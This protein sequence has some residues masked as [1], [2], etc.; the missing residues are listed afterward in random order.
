M[1]NLLTSPYSKDLPYWKKQSPPIKDQKFTD[2]LFPPNINSLLSKNEN[3][4][5]LDFKHGPKMEKRIKTEEI[6][7]MRA[8]EIFKNEKYSLFEKQIKISEISQGSL[9]DCYFLASIASLT[10]YPKLIYQ[11]FKTKNINNE[12]YFELIIFIDGKFQIVIVDD[13][14]PINIKNKRICFSRPYNN[15]IWICILE[16]AWAKINGGYTNIIKGWM[17][18]VL[19]AF[20][21]FQSEIIKHN[22]IKY[23][24][25]WEKIAEAKNNNFIITCSTRN[26]VDKYGL[27]NNHAYSFFGCT[28]IISN[29]KKIKLVKIRNI[30]KNKN[31]HGDWGD[32]SPLWGEEEKKQV[33]YYGKIKGL[34]YMS[35]Q[36]FYNYFDLTEICYVLYNSYSKNI[37]IN[38]QN[39]NN[40][41]IFNLY[42]EEDGY[43]FISLIRKMWR[44]NRQLVNTIIPSYLLIVSY[45]PLN[46]KINNY[47]YDYDA[48]NESYED[49]SLI[50]YL[51]KG[52][53]LIYAYHDLFHS[54]LKKE[55]FYIIKFDSTVKFKYKLMPNDHREKDFILLKNI[56]K[57]ILLDKYKDCILDQKYIYIGN[58][59]DKD[60]IGYKMIYN[61]KNHWIK[62][63]EDCSELKNVFILSSNLKDKNHEEEYEYIIP[64]KGF[65]IILGLPIDT[66]S[67]SDFVLKSKAFILEKKPKNILKNNLE[68][69]IK[70]YANNSVYYEDNN[71]SNFYDYLFIS[72]NDSKED[73]IPT[74]NLEESNINENTDSK[75]PKIMK[76]LEKVKNSDNTERLT[77][78]IIN[79]QNCEYIGQVNNLKQKEGKGCL[80]YKNSDHVL[81]GNFKNGKINGNGTVYNKN[82]DKIY[83]EG[84]FISGK[85][86]GKG[87]L[88]FYNGD[89]YEGEFEND[90][91]NGKGIYF[92]NCEKGEQKWEGNFFDG[93]MEGEGIFTNYD[94]KTEII[95][96]YKGKQIID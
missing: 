88:Y 12:G 72:L 51:N 5:F 37:Y 46:K 35:F 78:S 76:L 32:D 4:E 34:F 81:I 66:K 82:L 30:W 14:L 22:T 10:Q 15:E 50:K 13:Y 1:E 3:G 55:D 31:W 77:Y 6:A 42:L 67:P 63:T 36:D 44:F 83:F 24:D 28:E 33:N 93:N 18:H 16:K 40:G 59:I 84:N 27:V 43:F 21:G 47:F 20:T 52:Y 60:G 41:N 91:R 86:N 38:E 70:E 23:D 71:T 9:G 8:S 90:K 87:I 95:K 29:G 57:Q 25:L 64:P 92:F 94:G 96:Y 79:T 19:Q 75:Y 58:K 73:V 54:T 62:Y 68:I 61:N 26:N 85:K 89:R 74:I 39:I 56:L 45:N 53:Y 2:P 7:W 80:I 48:K 65:N 69:N 11:I 17:H 49:T